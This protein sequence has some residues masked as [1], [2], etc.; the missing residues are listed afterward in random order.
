MNEDLRRRCLARAAAAREQQRM[1][2]RNSNDQKTTL[3]A[4]VA[5][6]LRRDTMVPTEV[7]ARPSAWTEADEAALQE[8]L[9]QEAYLELMAATEESLMHDLGYG[10]DG[11]QRRQLQH[12]EDAEAE[13]EAYE[14]AQAAVALDAAEDQQHD[15]VLCPLCVRANLLHTSDGFVSC[16]NEQCALRLDARGHPAPLELLRERMDLLLREHSQRCQGQ[17]CCRRPL[18][19]EQS[20]GMLLFSCPTCGTT[21]GVV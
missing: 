17:A 8:A 18:Q 10:Q 20:L 13:Y 9:G 14:A 19:T 2:N 1:A 16:T 12:W 3:S 7:D 15:Q 4:I 21:C 6:E 5:E 11:M